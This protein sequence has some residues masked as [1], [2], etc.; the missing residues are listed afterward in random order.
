M[1]GAKT[2]SLPKRSSEPTIR[3]LA[4]HAWHELSDSEL[5]AAFLQRHPSD[6]SR[7]LSLANEILGHSDGFGGL[8]SAPPEMIE[9]EYGND[10]DI[11]TTLLA[12]RLMAHRVAAEAIS[13]TISL[14]SPASLKSYVNIQKLTRAN[15][16]LSIL[17]LDRHDKLIKDD[18]TSGDIGQ[19]NVCQD[20]VKKSIFLDAKSIVFVDYRSLKMDHFMRNF[21]ESVKKMEDILNIIGVSLHDYCL[22]Y[23]DEHQ[24]LVKQ[25]KFL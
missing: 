7:A 22:A 14:E 19:I 3:N 16:C 17:Y 15:R 1:H 20:V 2:H 18:H 10:E 13:D 24:S 8:L 6:Q 12:V 25:G 11:V 4:D 21:R 5:L 9:R 23:E